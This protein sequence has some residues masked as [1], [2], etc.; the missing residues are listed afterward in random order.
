[1][2]VCQTFNFLVKVLYIQ[3]LNLLLAQVNKYTLFSSNFSAAAAADSV[4]KVFFFVRE[5][6]NKKL[7][8]VGQSNMLTLQPIISYR[9]PKK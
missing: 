3:C 1:M 9:D 8:R 5:M 7:F 4:A 2:S 6:R